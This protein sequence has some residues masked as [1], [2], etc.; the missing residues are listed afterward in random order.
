GELMGEFFVLLRIGQ[1]AAG[2]N[3]KIVQRDG[4]PQT[5]ALAERHGDVAAVSLAAEVLV[6]VRLERQPRDDGHAMIALLTVEGDVLIAESLET[7]EWE[8]VVRTLRLLQADRV[9]PRRLDEACE[10]VDAQ[11]HR[12]DVPGCDLEL[13]AAGEK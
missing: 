7:L 5:R 4:I 2:R 8:L 13:H 3:V 9:R 1:V 10:E 12:I 11:P 6:R